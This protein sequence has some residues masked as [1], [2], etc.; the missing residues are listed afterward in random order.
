MAEANQPRG[1]VTDFTRYPAANY[2]GPRRSYNGFPLPIVE[3]PVTFSA[4]SQ[5]RTEIPNMETTQIWDWFAQQTNIRFNVTTFTSPERMQLL[6]TSRDYP[7][8]AW[9]ATVSVPMLNIAAEAG[10]LVPLDDLIRLYAPTWERAF[11]NYPTAR[12]V[13]KLGDGK[14]YGIP[15]IMHADYD[16]DLRD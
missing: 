8:I 10:V 3:R 14:I 1:G 13:T 5:F 9:Q 7:D 2:T 16:N 15:F 6:F 11:Q 12:S 4:W